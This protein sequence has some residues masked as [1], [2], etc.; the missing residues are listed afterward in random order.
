MERYDVIEGRIYTLKYN[1]YSSGRQQQ[2]ARSQQSVV[3][4]AF[5]GDYVHLKCIDFENN[6]ELMVLTCDLYEA[7]GINSS[8]R[9]N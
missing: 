6:P 8:E 5:E 2:M 9:Q 1:L 7:L 3:V 4:I